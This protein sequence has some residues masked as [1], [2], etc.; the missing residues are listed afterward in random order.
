MVHREE[1]RTTIAVEMGLAKQKERRTALQLEKRCLLSDLSCIAEELRTIGGE[2]HAAC[3]A[4]EQGATI[5]RQQKQMEALTA[6]VQKVSAQL[7]LNKSAPQTVLNN[8]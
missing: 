5:A 4:E 6:A 3:G 2:R 8:R 7:E 1:H